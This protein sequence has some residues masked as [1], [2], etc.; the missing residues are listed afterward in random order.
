MIRL[1]NLLQLYSTFTEFCIQ[2]KLL[3][4]YL[5]V[6]TCAIN[7]AGIAGRQQS[8][9]VLNRQQLFEIIRAQF[10]III[11]ADLQLG[12]LIW[13]LS[14]LIKSTFEYKLGQCARLM[15]KARVSFD[16]VEKSMLED[17]DEARE[18]ILPAP[19][20]STAAGLIGRHSSVIMWKALDVRGHSVVTAGVH[21][22]GI[23]FRNKLTN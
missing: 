6:H 4:S 7:A 16:A 17:D 22:G 1:L 12:A 20:M 19:C 21:F 15:C 8:R 10:L 14:G 11:C 2:M 5:H 3:D 18:Q 23:K 13:Q 9:P